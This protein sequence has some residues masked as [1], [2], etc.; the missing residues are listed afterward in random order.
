[1][2]F[3]NAGHSIPQASSIDCSSCVI[4]EFEEALS[5]IIR[6]IELPVS[7]KRS[8]MSFKCTA[9]VAPICWPLTYDPKLAFIMGQQQAINLFER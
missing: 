3:L 1:M 7:A 6:S 8:R 5:V 9:S 4:K 2:W